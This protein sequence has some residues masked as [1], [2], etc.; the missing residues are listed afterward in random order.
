MAILNS[1]DTQMALMP[2]QGFVA[3]PQQVA[4]DQSAKLIAALQKQVDSMQ[5]QMTG[6]KHARAISDV[7]S[8]PCGSQMPQAIADAPAATGAGKTAKGKKA[9]AKGDKDPKCPS[10]L[11]GCCTRSNQATGRRKMCYAYNLGKCNSVAD[12]AECAKGA[13]LCMKSVNGVAC[14]KSHPQTKHGR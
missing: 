8:G 14:S 5:K 6:Q 12:G 4:S 3:V 1:L 10:A 13:H 2:R 11:K 9:D 7:F